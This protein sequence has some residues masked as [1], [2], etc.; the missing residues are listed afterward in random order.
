ML[1]PRRRF[2]SIT[3]SSLTSSFW[4]IPVIARREIALA[5]LA[6]LALQPAQIEDQLLSCRGG[7]DGHQPAVTKD[8]LPDG[9]PDPP[10]GVAGETEPAL[11]LESGKR[12]HQTDIARGHQF[13]QRHAVAAKP[14]GDPHSCRERGS[15][16]RH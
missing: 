6:A 12:P 3:S 15:P 16:R 7:A 5:E 11:R 10:H 13:G 2:I 1:A 8:M 14:A 9:C 4:A